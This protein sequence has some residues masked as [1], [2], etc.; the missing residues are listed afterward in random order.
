[1]AYPK[2]TPIVATGAT[3]PRYIADRFADVINVRDFGAK[4]DGVTDDTAAF[5]AAA[6]TG[7]T[8]FV[9]DG[10][11]VLSSPVAG[12]FVGYDADFTGGLVSGFRKLNAKQSRLQSLAFEGKCLGEDNDGHHPALQTIAYDPF[13]NI[14]Y[15]TWNVNGQGTSIRALD[16]KTRNLIANSNTFYGAFGHQGT[17]LY[18]P[19]KQ[20]PVKFLSTGNP[21]TAADTEV[22]SEYNKLNLISWDYNSPNSFTIDKTWYIWDSTID[23][24]NYDYALTNIAITEDRQYL[25]G[26]MSLS[27]TGETYGGIAVFRIPLTTLMSLSDNTII[28]NSADIFWVSY[29]KFPNLGQGIAADDKYLYCLG[30]NASFS[31][32]WTTVFDVY[33]GKLVFNR[34]ASKE[35]LTYKFSDSYDLPF[36]IEAEALGFLPVNGENHLCMLVSVNSYATGTSNVLRKPVYY[37]LED[38]QTP[39]ENS[40][41]APYTTGYKTKTSS[42][43]LDCPMP[44]WFIAGSGS[45]NDLSGGVWNL[46]NVVGNTDFKPILQLVYRGNTPTDLRIRTGTSSSSDDASVKA[47]WESWRKILVASASN[48]LPSFFTM[49]S[50]GS[51]TEKLAIRSSDTTRYA[52]LQLTGSATF[53]VSSG[54]YTG[55]RTENGATDAN[56]DFVV[57]VGWVGPQASASGAVSLGSASRMWSEV[58]ASNGTIQ[59]SDVRLKDNVEVPTEQLMRAWGKVNYKVF[60]MKQA[61]AKKGDNARIH[62]GVIAQ[63]VQEAFASEG[64]DANRYGLFCYDKWENEWEEETVVD[65]EAVLDEKGNEISPAQTHVERRQIQ[66]AGEAYSIRYDEALALEC[67]YQR[68]RMEQLEER[69]N[70]LTNNRN[71]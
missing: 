70:Q 7:K 27:Y 48:V 54:S 63:E 28:V 41:L 68:W 44:G 38:G 20:D 10:S 2:L 51:D 1:M 60:Q 22:V 66:K 55:L 43:F 21:Y 32:H 53:L 30:S 47:E 8:V 52:G 4:G 71:S 33:S 40:S 13:D 34:G 14:L 3:E 19:T 39:V 59:T 24:K 17:Q 37:D 61:I 42:D 12:P 67:A 56:G 5:Q 11:Y 35:G 31:P 57:G 23:G 29:E 6:V 58:H 15:G 46:L 62:V 36:A 64:L 18:R 65:V 25:V 16:W 49:N 50:N 26:E 69:V 9:P 45:V